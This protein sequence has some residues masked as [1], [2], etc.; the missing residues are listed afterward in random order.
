MVTR[1]L[2]AALLLV[3]LTGLADVSI[4]LDRTEVAVNESFGVTFLVD[5]QSDADPDFT[6]LSQ[7][8]EILVG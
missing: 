3:P 2:L 7:D 1:C 6:P 8:F 5:G 4:V